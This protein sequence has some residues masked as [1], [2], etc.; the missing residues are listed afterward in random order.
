[1]GIFWQGEEAAGFTI[2][3]F[4]PQGRVLQPAL[5]L[6]AWPSVESRVFRLAGD[7]WTVWACDV[8][9]HSW[10][11]AARWRSLVLGTLN[12]LLN[13]GAT[14]AWC[15]L[16][17]AFADPPGLFEPKHMSDGV[18]TARINGQDGIFGPPGLD[19]PFVK[20]TDEQLITFRR[21]AGLGG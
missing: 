17:G 10:P 1:L 15:A 6:G 14:V 18:W 7:D 8:R 21:A 4:W 20:L 9:I 12:Q 16:E 5:D 3:G 19:E 11:A 2:Y 13:A